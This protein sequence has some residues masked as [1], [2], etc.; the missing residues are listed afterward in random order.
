MSLKKKPL[1]NTKNILKSFPVLFLILF[2]IAFFRL[3]IAGMQV[4]KTKMDEIERFEN[5]LLDYESKIIASDLGKRI[6]DL[7]FMAEAYLPRL[8][9]ESDIQGIAEEWRIYSEYKGLYDQ[10]RFIDADG[11]EKIRIN[12]SEDETYIV[13]QAALQNKKDRYYFTETAQLNKGQ[14]LISRIDL[15]MENGVI[16]IPIKPTIR[17]STPIFSENDQFFGILIL[18]YLADN[19]L[20][21]FET[22][23]NY[24]EGQIF[25]LNPDSYWI[26]SDDPEQNWSFMFDDKQEINFKE[27]YPATW[28]EM[29]APDH[30]FITEAGFYTYKTIDL[31]ESLDNEHLINDQGI[32]P[33]ENEFRI[34]SLISSDNKVGDIFK[35]DL[36]SRI[37][38]IINANIPNFFIILVVSFLGSFSIAIVRQSYFQIKFFSEY[39]ALTGTFNRRAGLDLLTK[40]L[41]KDDRRKTG[42][43]LCFVDINGLKTVNDVLGHDAG[44]ELIMTVVNVIKQTIRE[45]D[46]IIRMGGDEFLI[47]FS[48]VSQEM[49]EAVWGRILTAFEKINLTENLCY[50]VSASH[51]IVEYEPTE[52]G[53]IDKWIKDADEI[54][55]AEKRELKKK[56]IIVKKQ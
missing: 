43:C 14:I 3:F 4:E 48:N 8:L 19:F 46:F 34:V 52:N 11:I 55:Y 21:E 50:R 53:D 37:K 42:I 2:S 5:G 45:S 36:I 16:E 28:Q 47:V 24:S 18:N 10:V 17:L 39:D 27:S 22:I 56:E 31:K 40:M 7:H 44:D 6:N 32:F 29:Q 15:N 35:T 33:D 41:V 54:M 23:A 30:S 26:Y 12:Y 51:G 1:V 20:N 9:S 38:R 25:L 13:D 49:A